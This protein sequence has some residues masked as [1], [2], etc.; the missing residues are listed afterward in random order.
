[1]IRRIGE[2]GTGNR[3]VKERQE[4][5]FGGAGDFLNRLTQLGESRRIARKTDSLFESATAT[6]KRTKVMDD[7][8]LR[9]FHG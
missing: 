6:P 1:V 4:N 7:G 9:E 3:P 2:N 8:E 5:P